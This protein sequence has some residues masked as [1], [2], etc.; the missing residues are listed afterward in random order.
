MDSYSHLTVR[1]LQFLG[2]NELAIH[3][4]N[5]LCGR[6]K[7]SI[8]PQIEHAVTEI[9]QIQVA[10]K[11]SSNSIFQP[12]IED[13]MQQVADQNSLF[14]LPDDELTVDKNHFSLQ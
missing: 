1:F 14:G 3:Y 12:S 8:N 4:A 6:G 7:V 11:R 5:M 10:S 9:M 13:T 2:Y